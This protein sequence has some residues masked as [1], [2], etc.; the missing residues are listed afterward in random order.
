MYFES[1][2][3]LEKTIREVS[4]AECSSI[5]L[6]LLK[7][8]EETK[9]V[10]FKTEKFL[11]TPVIKSLGPI[12]A[13]ANGFLNVSK[14]DS[15]N[16]AELLR[17]YKFGTIRRSSYLYS[18]GVVLIPH[19]RTDS[20]GFYSNVWFDLTAR[21]EREFVWGRG[22]NMIPGAN[23]INL[24]K[25]R[26]DHLDDES[27][28]ITKYAYDFGGILRFLDHE[29]WSPTKGAPLNFSSWP[30]DYAPRG[31]S[32][33][34]LGAQMQRWRHP[35][36]WYGSDNNPYVY[37][38][39]DSV[40]APPPPPHPWSAYKYIYVSAFFIFT[41]WEEAVAQYGQDHPGTEV[42]VFDATTEFVFATSDNRTMIDKSCNA[43]GRTESP[44][45]DCVVTISHMPKVMQDAWKEVKNEEDTFRIA[46][47]DGEKHFM[48]RAPLFRFTPEG[49]LDE[50]IPPPMNACILWVRPYSSVEGEVKNALYLLIG[51]SAAVLILDVVLAVCEVL[52]VGVPLIKLSAAM[53]HLHDMDLVNAMRCTDDARTAIAVTQ[54]RNVINGLLFAVQNLEQYKAFLPA[55]LFQEEDTEDHDDS[56]T[57]DTKDISGQK[58]SVPSRAS[59]A[60]T[61]ASQSSVVVR[62]GNNMQLQTVPAK[63]ALLAVRV[64]AAE[65]GHAEYTTL[66]GYLQDV[67]SARRGMLHGI[68][69]VEHTLFHISWGL[70]ARCPLST[71]AKYAS[72][73]ASLLPDAPTRV[74]SAIVS[75]SF[76]V[77]N[78]GNSTLRGVAVC[79][80]ETSKLAAF[81]A[82]SAHCMVLSKAASV[83]ILGRKAASLLEGQFLT[84]YLCKCDS[85]DRMCQLGGVSVQKNEEWMYTLHRDLS[86]RDPVQRHLEDGVPF[87]DI[88]KQDLTEVQQLLFKSAEAVNKV[89]SVTGRLD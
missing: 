27:G 72:E 19:V 55:A 4:R 50:S 17:R 77:G 88:A 73:V 44:L 81:Q 40:W 22:G 87:E 26:G 78:V 68:Q 83:T 49:G 10:V 57:S 9:S 31:W 21:K 59:S 61:G 79:G 48:R 35:L 80:A 32:R 1:V 39:F 29:G 2:A 28:E 84:H 7:S 6:D 20:A 67:I 52:V 16:W 60:Y 34:T 75:G 54:I 38:S 46:D 36:P 76:Q 53:T 51:F 13:D 64:V 14:S 66:I 85:G 5:Q 15:A 37:V 89:W 62:T 11:D 42:I 30:A 65:V 69:A 70:T 43:A 82:F 58:S 24:T 3:S 74:S 25:A 41:A 18:M 23:N 12:V 63:G 47:L 86:S 71:S 45:E 8:V 56:E 33:G